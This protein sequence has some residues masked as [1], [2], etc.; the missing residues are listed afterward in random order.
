MPFKKLVFC[1]YLSFTW[2]G[3]DLVFILTPSSCTPAW[4][5]KRQEID[6][7]WKFDA[8]MFVFELSDGIATVITTFDKLKSLCPS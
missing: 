3:L 8:K 2:H 5:L 4:A 1:Y 7:T 6:D